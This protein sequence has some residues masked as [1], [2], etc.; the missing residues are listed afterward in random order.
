MNEILFNEVKKLYESYG[1][2]VDKAIDTLKKIR[3]SIHC[4]QG[5]DVQGFHS[6]ESLSGGISVTG[7]YPYRASNI[8]ELREDIDQVLSLVPYQHKL[9]LHAIYLDSDEHV[10]LDKIEPKHF[11]SWVEW[12][13]E[14][15]L[16]LDFNPTLFSHPNSKSGFTLS[17][18]NS[19]IQKFWINHVNQS[20]KIAAYFGEALNI[21]SICN[22]WIPDGFKDTP[23]LRLEP[24]KRLEEALNSI[25]QQN[26]DK[27]YLIDTLESKLFGIGAESYT[28]GSHEF[29]LGYAVKNQKGLC[30]DSGHFHP[31]EHV[32]DKLS[33][34][35]LFVNDILLHVSRP[36]RWDSDH[37]VT[38][39]DELFEIM[40]SI[41]ADDLINKVHIGLDY[42]DASI[43]RIA[44]WVQGIRN[45]Q[46]SLL[47]SLL[48]PFDKFKELDHENK[49]TDR[50]ILQEELKSLPFN[51]IY[52]YLCEKE[53]IPMGNQWL[54]H[55]NAYE[56]TLKENRK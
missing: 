36:V 32:Y 9:N 23:F 28:T 50:L 26:Y 17:S 39:D 2:D 27:K 33:S 7:N 55:I 47:K 51:V 22:I 16:G 35:S 4:W 56:K 1:V 46:K 54:E 53:N 41:T 45:T 25:Y 12:A 44:A 14:R 21:P 43:N 29:Y 18:M 34:V 37:V 52:D 40:N 15:N 30:L 38:L 5:D 19:D 10:E 11:S 8:H 24:R 3:I 48:R 6:K 42:F 31:T 20:R 49:Y 13:K